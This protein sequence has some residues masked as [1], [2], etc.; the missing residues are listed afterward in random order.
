MISTIGH[1]IFRLH[2]RMPLVIR[3]AWYALLSVT[4]KSLVRHRGEPKRRLLIS[5]VRCHTAGGY[6]YQTLTSL[7]RTKTPESPVALAGRPPFRG[8]LD[9]LN[10]RLSQSGTYQVLESAPLA[11]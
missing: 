8:E 10:Q 7:T 2:H 11:R 6:V 1:V 3:R 4:M 9:F 5:H